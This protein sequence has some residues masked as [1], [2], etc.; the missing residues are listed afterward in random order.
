MTPRRHAG[1]VGLALGR[2]AL[3]TA[4]PRASAGPGGHRDRD[5]QR[6]ADW[7]CTLPVQFFH[8]LIHLAAPA[9]P[10]RLG[11]D[12]ELKN[13][14]PR[15]TRKS[16]IPVPPIPDS[17]EIKAAES[18]IGKSPVSRFGRDRETGPRLPVAVNR[19]LAS[20]IGDSDTLLVRRARARV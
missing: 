20:E 6:R 5:W 4:S 8:G 7:Q 9:A 10:S 1:S 12:T 3:L 16:P 15:Q 17:A 13:C 11:Q 19:E 18:G 2:A 14:G